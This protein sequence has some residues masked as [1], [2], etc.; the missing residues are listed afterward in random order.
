MA[1]ARRPGGRPGSD[2]TPGDPPQPD[3]ATPLALVR[4]SAQPKGRLTCGSP[5]RATR[6]Q[7]WSSNLPTR[8]TRSR[9]AWTE[10]AKHPPQR[11]PPYPGVEPGGQAL[12]NLRST[13]L[14]QSA[15]SGKWLSTSSTDGTAPLVGAA[16]L[17]KSFISDSVPQRCG[18]RMAKPCQIDPAAT[19]Q[20]Q[21]A[22]P[23]SPTL[24][25]LRRPNC[26]SAA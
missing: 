14:S 11:T 26:T 23:Q 2:Y 7:R 12:A 16:T 4:R 24:L 20:S 10:A 9:T 8:S 18:R 15:G 25:S 6:C 3:R 1:A 22:V 13:L 21:E 5:R 17:H 19:H